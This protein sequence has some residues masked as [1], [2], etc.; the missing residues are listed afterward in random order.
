[1]MNLRNCYSFLL[2]AFIGVICISGCSP[3]KEIPPSDYL[4]SNSI[5]Q[6][7][8][9]SKGLD[10]NGHELANIFLNHLADN[11]P[12]DI[13]KFDSTV[14]ETFSKESSLVKELMSGKVTLL[15]GYG[16]QTLGTP[17]QW[18]LAPKGDL[19]WT[20]HLSR[21]YWLNPL[22][23][24]WRATK[25]PVYSQKIVDVLI[26]WI[27]KN[28]IGSKKLSWGKEPLVNTNSPDLVREGFFFTYVDGPWTSLSA[29]ARLDNWTYLLSMIHD[30]PQMT[31]RNLSVIF[32][33]L[34][35]DHRISMINY[36]RKMNQFIAIASSLVNYCWYFPFLKGASE[37]G[38][39]GLERVRF[40]A[41]S[42]IYPDG[43]MAECSP[44]YATGS[45]E[46]VNKIV[47]GDQIKGGHLYKELDERICKALRYF[48][49]SADP[50]GNSPRI[51]KGK[52]SV[53]PLVDRIGA[54]CNDPQVDY[55]CSNGAKGQCADFLSVSY[56]W[57]GHVIFR[58][59]WRKNSTWLFFEP[60][61]RGSGH[62]DVA[63]L[64]I[65]LKSKG[66]WLLTDPGYYTYSN[67]GEEGEMADYLHSSAAHNIALVD[68]QNQLPFEWGKDRTYNT[69]PGNYSWSDNGKIAKAEGVYNFGYGREGNIKVTHKREIIYHR[70]ADKFIIE[71]TFRG[72]GV[73]QVELLWQL[74][75]EAKLTLKEKALTIENGKAAAQFI[76]AGNKPFRIESSKGSKN[77]LSGWFS[78]NY[79]V[80]EPGNT[81]RVTAEGK[82]P[83]VF[84]TEIA[85]NQPK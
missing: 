18:F 41:N 61:P 67:S 58:S 21:H 31:N 69:E 60:G 36:P 22:A 71:D 50:E 49:L 79:G 68:K 28:P 52:S 76:I 80:L 40:F 26:D 2:P 85:I 44:N 3:E 46:R 14:S 66:E 24:A 12:V 11:G 56:D 37:A 55:L 70:E 51:A 73:H 74:P 39:I 16:L 17:V 54:L 29:H 47:R 82:L 13:Q 81:V 75:P 5:L 64:N 48:V 33:S 25:N 53:L 63:T 78:L 27:G 8:K 72:D 23:H 10:P 1:M 83:I 7:E 34:A 57:A 38:I 4:N 32:N 20:T 6:L 45:L 30:S 59:D 65:Q 62:S 84:K 35:N 9:V 15:N 19:Q 77:P 42:E 43:S